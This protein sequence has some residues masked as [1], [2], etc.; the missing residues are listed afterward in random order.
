MG[1]GQKNARAQ[2]Q[3]RAEAGLVAAADQHHRDPV[4][5]AA[6]RLGADERARRSERRGERCDKRQRLKEAGR[7]ARSLGG[8]MRQK[9]WRINRPPGGRRF[10][11]LFRA[12]H[13]FGL[14]S[15]ASTIHI[16]F[17]RKREHG[18]NSI[19]NRGFAV[20]AALAMLCRAGAWCAS[21]SAAYAAGSDAAHGGCPTAKAAE[22]EARA[23]GEAGLSQRRRDARNG[24]VASSARAVRGAQIRRRPTQSRGAVGEALPHRRRFRLRDHPLASGRASRAC[25][26]GGWDGENRSAPRRA[27]RT[28]RTSP[29]KRTRPTNRRPR[30]DFR[31][32]LGLAGAHAAFGCR[33]R[34]GSQP[35]G[36]RRARGRG[37]CGR[38]RVRRR[39]RLVSR[40]H[41][42]LRRG[43]AR[44]RPAQTRRDLDPRSL[45]QGRAHNA[46]LDPH[47]SRSV[48]R[49]GPGH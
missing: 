38:P 5:E 25:R 26:D 4:G 45:A 28:K 31:R 30:I 36:V 37:L 7:A 24:Q 6:V 16:A 44:H 12:R 8:F 29:T 10:S 13:P 21:C 3:G 23:V 33:G 17:S 2:H 22:V 43:R 39:G 40:R 35:S 46:G 1:G 41:R 9:A 48:E 15:R 42:A 20:M 49:Q 14:Q 19:R 47:G 18:A 11:A 32:E 34:S 27:S